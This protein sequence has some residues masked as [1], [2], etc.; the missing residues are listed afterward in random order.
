MAEYIHLE[1]VTPERAVLSEDVDDVIL[2]GILG[3]MDI[4]PGHLPLLTLLDIGGI[5][6]RR[7]GKERHFLINRGYAEILGNR[8]T[9]LTEHCEG[10]NEID[11]EQA[12]ERLKAAEEEVARLEEL[13]KTEAVEEDLFELHRTALKRERMRLAFAEEGEG[14]EG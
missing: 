14:E 6:A 1:V 5:V 13:S 10:V 9:V 4:L 3:Q 8:V 12:R 7:D 11:V 2:P